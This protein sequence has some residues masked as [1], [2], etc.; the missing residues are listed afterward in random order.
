MSADVHCRKPDPRIYEIA[1]DRLGVPAGDC[2]FIDN[3]AENLRVARSLGMDTVLFNRDGEEYD[4]KIVYS[5][6][7]L[8]QML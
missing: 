4:G 6:Q 8:A 3:S 1:L 5:F 2:I 7:E